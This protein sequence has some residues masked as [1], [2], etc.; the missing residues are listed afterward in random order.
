MSGQGRPAVPP[1]EE[2]DAHVWAHDVRRRPPA[3]AVEFLAGLERFFDGY[4]GQADNWHRRNAGYHRAVTQL[5]RFHVP[6]GA[7][8][9]E[10]GS[11]TGD[12]LAA[13]EPARGV[14]V[15]LSAEMVRLAA[16]KFPHLDFRKMAAEE[17]DLGG[18]KFDYILL[19]DLIPFL[20]DI[21]RVFA[22]LRAACTPRTRLVL[23]W[24]SRLWQPLLDLA[25]RAGLKHPQPFLNWTTPEDVRG[26]LYLAGFETVHQARHILLPKQIPLATTLANR[27]L[28]HLPGLRWTALTNWI[29]ARPLG[30]QAQ[31]TPPRVSVICPCRN[32]AGNIEQ[33]VERLPRMGSHTELVFVEGHSSDDTRARCER[34][35]AARPD[36]DIKVLVQEGKGKADAV[37]RGFAA[38]SGDVLMILDADLSVAPEDLPRFYDA[39]VSGK[40][41][42]I[43]GSRLV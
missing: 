37:R 24:H 33:I 1:S 23:H 5:V 18:E 35:A 26:M 14:G 43:N 19:S 2:A 10:V 31:A 13:V 39:I 11:G 17:L 28:V 4:A 40:G 9:L 38:A 41:E 6:A 21:V 34:I 36:R 16:S 3:T 7:R 15:D 20:F 22:R 27:F 29:V 42:F 8:V 30:L 25:A 32:E 12:L